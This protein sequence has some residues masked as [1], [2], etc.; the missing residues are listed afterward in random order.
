MAGGTGTLS[1][2]DWSVLALDAVLLGVTAWYARRRPSDARDY[3]VGHGQMPSW[4]VAISVLAS[5]MSVAT[6]LGAPELAYRGD[7][8]YLIANVGAIAAVV[9]VAVVFIPAFYRARVVTVYDLIGDAYGPAARTGA[10]AA[11]LLGRLLASGARLYMAAIPLAALLAAGAQDRPEL[12][13]AAVI[14]LSVVATVAALAG[15]IASII[16]I[17]VLQFAI[18]MAAVVA[19]L[20]VLCVRIP[21]PW[22]AVLADLQA[23]RHGAGAKLHVVDWSLH[24]HAANTVWTA[25]T[26]YLLLNV[27]AYGAD[28]DL[29]QRMLT[30]RSALQ[31]ARSALL[32]IA[33]NIPVLLA[34]LAIGL[35]LWVVYQDPHL[36]GAARPAQLPSRDDQALVTFLLHEMPAGLAGLMLAGLFASAFTSLLSAINAMAAAGVHDFYRR[37]NPDRD[38]AHYLRAG[39][40]GVIAAGAALAGMAA[41]CIAWQQHAHQGLIEF[42]LGIMAIPYSGLVGV[43]LA[44]LVLRRGSPAS[45]LTGLIVGIATSAAGAAWAPWSWPW[46]M[47][48][49]TL[50]TVLV[51]ARGPRLPVA[52]A[53]RA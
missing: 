45:A 27:A 22:T 9:I 13:L 44:A 19:V 24:L 20:V 6:F 50:L 47:T 31:G 26:G 25:L 38:E 21:A 28:Q 32:A 40:W 1:T 35:G 42:A 48:F 8:T 2:A 3:F 5:A 16:W 11:F 15:G 12:L 14:G 29:A 7:L 18:T 10:S 49:A 52:A 53:E 33:M 17:D 46:T 41:L 37:W 51:V 36:M 43:F 4:A 23:A 39:R 34:F 30:C